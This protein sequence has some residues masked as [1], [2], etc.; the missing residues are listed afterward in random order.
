MQS[1]VTQH[2]K[3]STKHR[4]ADSVA[5]KRQDIKAE[6]REDG[7]AGD[8]DVQAVLFVDEREVAGFV[9]DE[10]FEGVVEDGELL[11]KG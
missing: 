4:Q 5:P 11:F 10:A 1:H 2:Q 9:D 6:T 7:G 3:P 8:F